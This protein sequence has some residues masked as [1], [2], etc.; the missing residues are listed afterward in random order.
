VSLEE[1]K[2]LRDEWF[3]L[4]W[5]WQAAHWIF[6]FIVAAGSALVASQLASGSY[7]RDVLAAVVAVASAAYAAFQ[8]GTKAQA[9]RQAWIGLRVE[10]MRLEGV[11]PEIIGAV[12]AGEEIITSGPRP[13][14][15]KQKRR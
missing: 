14:L 2:R 12:L 6:L 4:H 13:S 10:V 8:P 3:T 15:T 11:N 1:A 7:W 9:Y 5:W